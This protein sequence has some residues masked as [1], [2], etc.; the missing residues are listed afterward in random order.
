MSEKRSLRKPKELVEQFF[1]QAEKE[2]KQAAID[3]KEWGYGYACSE[4]DVISEAYLLLNEMA[5]SIVAKWEKAEKGGEPD[6]YR[7]SNSFFCLF[8]K[9]KEK[10]RDVFTKREA[11]WKKGIEAGFVTDRVVV[12]DPNDAGQITKA[13][14]VYLEL[15]MCNSDIESMSVVISRKEGKSIKEAFRDRYGSVEGKRRRKRWYNGGRARLC[16][17]LKQKEMWESNGE[18]FVDKILAIL[19]KMGCDE[20]REGEGG[21][22]LEGCK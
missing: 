12:S 18:G 13:V 15:D 14:A 8:Y 7:Y 3:L 1:S 22:H 2:A 9:F 4:D 6:Q 19:E 16:K 17:L 11:N 21:E 5:V 10:L 20:D